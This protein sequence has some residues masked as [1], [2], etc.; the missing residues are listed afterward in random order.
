M[1]FTKIIRGILTFDSEIGV[2]GS[3]WGFQGFFQRPL[4]FLGESRKLDGISQKILHFP[5]GSSKEF[6][7]YFKGFHENFFGFSMT[8]KLRNYWA[9]GQPH[10]RHN[11]QNLRIKLSHTVKNNQVHCS[12]KIFSSSDIFTQLASLNMF[13]L[14][15]IMIQI[16]KVHWIVQS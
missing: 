14:N 9:S 16:R 13:S 8:T 7:G 15:K 6:L 11:F 10:S 2:A 3:L 1:N 5:Q 12:P 4:E